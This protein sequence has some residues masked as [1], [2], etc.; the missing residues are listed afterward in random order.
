MTPDRTHLNGQDLAREV[1]LRKEAEAVLAETT[2]VR[3][4]YLSAARGLPRPP[5]DPR[6]TRW[7][8]YS[9]LREQQARVLDEQGELQATVSQMRDELKA[10]D[11]ELAK[12]KP[13]HRP[14]LWAEPKQVR[15]LRLHEHSP[16]PLAWA[17]TRARWAVPPHVQVTDTGRPTYEGLKH[18]LAEK[19]AQLDEALAI[20][21]ELSQ[22]MQ[23]K[24]GPATPPGVCPACGS[25]A[26]A[27]PAAPP[28]PAAA[29]FSGVDAADADEVSTVECHMRSIGTCLM[30]RACPP[31]GQRGRRRPGGN[32]PGRTHVLGAFRGIAQRV[33]LCCLIDFARRLQVTTET[34]VTAAATNLLGGLLKKK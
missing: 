10:K 19:D 25:G 21:K 17:P 33:V 29:P 32:H 1:K 3:G 26:A 34:P 23:G 2:R 9:A 27:A 18:K 28:A 22:A 13:D 16:A 24:S 12:L 20:I 14:S 15:R 4:G 30:L 11:A 31:A 8:A 5:C 6:R 7:Q